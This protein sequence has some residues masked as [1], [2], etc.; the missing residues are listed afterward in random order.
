MLPLKFGFGQLCLLTLLCKSKLWLKRQ[1]EETFFPK[2]KDWL[3]WNTQASG[4]WSQCIVLNHHLYVMGF[5]LSNYAI[6]EN[7]P[8]ESVSEWY[9]IMCHARTSMEQCDFLCSMNSGIWLMSKNPCTQ[10]AARVVGA[11]LC[12]ILKFYSILTHW[13]W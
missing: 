3:H 6:I 1:V 4:N 9:E 13:E 5:I 10:P 11:V 8:S 7:F 2:C 12:C